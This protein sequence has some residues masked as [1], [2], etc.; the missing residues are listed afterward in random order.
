MAAAGVPLGPPFDIPNFTISGVLPPYLGPTA[1]DPASMSPY[2]TTLTRIANKLCGSDER[3]VIFRGLLQYRLALSGIGLSSGFQWLSG[4]FLEDIETIESR[5]PRD[6]DVVTFVRR[7]APVAVDAA[8]QI[9]F[10]THINLFQP[11]QAKATYRCDAYFIDM[12]TGPENIVNQTRY[13]FG[14]FGHRR[15]GVWKGLLQLPLAVT[16]DDTD[17]SGIVGP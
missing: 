17:A 12:D 6:I 7:P 4:S 14:L 8:W 10:N 16:Q 11:A 5:P 9:F 3:K 2:E 1:T 15:T 13:W